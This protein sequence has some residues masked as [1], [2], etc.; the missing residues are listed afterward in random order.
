M[1]YIGKAGKALYRK[2][3]WLLFTKKYSSQSEIRRG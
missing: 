3:F 1:K 2:T